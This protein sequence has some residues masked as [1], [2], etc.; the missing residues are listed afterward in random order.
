MLDVQQYTPEWLNDPTLSFD[1]VMRPPSYLYASLQQALDDYSFDQ[2]PPAYEHSLGPQNAIAGPSTPRPLP[3]LRQE[4]LSQL[5]ERES[6]WED[7][8]EE[9]VDDGA[10]E[11]AEDADDE[12]ERG[13]DGEGEADDADDANVEARADAEVEAETSA[14]EEASLAEDGRDSDSES[15]LLDIPLPEMPPGDHQRRSLDP[16]DDEEHQLELP[17][18]PQD[19][20]HIPPPAYHLRSDAPRPSPGR[21]GAGSG[22][23]SCLPSSH[24]CTS[25]PGFFRYLSRIA[26]AAQ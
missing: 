25:G 12:F 22:F 19:R 8:D 23:A 3:Q 20:P 7:S 21:S 15:T 18:I 14:D 1:D 17:P 26:S 10:S 4:R 16:F 5:Y 13:A 6:I 24:A 9:E 11:G 2:Q